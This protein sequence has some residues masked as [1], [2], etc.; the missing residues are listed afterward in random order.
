MAFDSEQGQII[1]ISNATSP[2]IGLKHSLIQRNPEPVRDQSS[3]VVARQGTDSHLGGGNIFPT[4]PRPALE[5][6][7]HSILWIPGHSTGQSGRDVALTTHPHL[8]LKLKKEV[9]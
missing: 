5:P 8:A 2:T 1:F 4:S 6:T 9:N 3:V 7:Q